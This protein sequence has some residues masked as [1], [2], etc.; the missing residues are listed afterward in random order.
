MKSLIQIQNKMLE[1]IKENI[2]FIFIDVILGIII[3]SMMISGNLVNSVDGVWNTSQYWAKTWETSLGRGI[4]YFV[5]KMRAGL[6]SMPLN[7]VLALFCIS[8]GGTLVLDIFQVRSKWLGR[9]VC[10]DR[11]S[12]V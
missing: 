4:L 3:Y 11:K 2:K 5:D 6:V 8:S 1:W 9:L 12:V 7:T 10:L